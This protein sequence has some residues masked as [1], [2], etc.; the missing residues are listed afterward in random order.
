MDRGN[1]RPAARRTRVKERHVKLCRI[2][3]VGRESRDTA[4]AD[5]VRSS[6][7]GTPSERG[8]FETTGVRT[9]TAATKTEASLSP[10]EDTL[11]RRLERLGGAASGVA[12]SGPAG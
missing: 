10:G 9:D 4:F 11:E 7:K 5:R 12:E 2:T 6:E 1:L 8:E 3:G